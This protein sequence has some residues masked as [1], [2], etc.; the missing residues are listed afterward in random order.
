V[1]ITG[2]RKD[3]FGL[4]LSFQDGRAAGIME[5]MPP[6]ERKTLY[7]IQQVVSENNKFSFI[8]PVK[9]KV[10]YRN[11]TKAGLLRIP[12]FVSWDN[13]IMKG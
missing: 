13:E 11:I 3:E 10:K 2:L 6:A 9:C 8:V 12:T 4:L 1:L 5:F 7:R